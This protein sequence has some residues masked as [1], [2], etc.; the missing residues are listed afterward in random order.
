MKTPNWKHWLALPKIEAE[1]ALLL[2]FNICPKSFESLM[3]YHAYE[4]S[5]TKSLENELSERV[6]FL[7]ANLRNPNLFPSLD[8][9]ENLA[10]SKISLMEFSRWAVNVMKWESL[11]LEL[12]ALAKQ[13]K[14]SVESVK[15]LTLFRNNQI[16]VIEASIR[17][18]DFDPMK[19]PNGG[20]GKVEKLCLTKRRDLFRSKNSFLEAWKEALRANRIRTEKHAQYARR[21]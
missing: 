16:L 15:E 6:D 8:A 14:P 4:E 18:L 1:Q 3:G 20:K 9:S 19:I 5:W 10:H 7:E 11:P 2:S 21:D 13:Q 12:S 17:E